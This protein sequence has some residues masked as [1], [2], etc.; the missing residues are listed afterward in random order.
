MTDEEIKQIFFLSDKPRPN[1][2]IAD[3][4]DIIQFARNIE[5]FVIERM[6]KE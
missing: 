1:P 3:E 6:K 5:A 2:I 4:V